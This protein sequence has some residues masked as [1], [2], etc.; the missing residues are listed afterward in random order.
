M[1]KKYVIAPN[2]VS[3]AVITPVGVVMFEDGVATDFSDEQAEFF[4]EQEAYELSDSL[5][6]IEKQTIVE[7]PPAG[8]EP[9]QRDSQQLP[10]LQNRLKA[11]LAF[12]KANNVDLMGINKRAKKPVLEAIYA[13][14][15]E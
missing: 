12:A 13:Q 7:N 9:E 11:I 5:E 8:D 1:N 4:E 14:L 2:N 10:V 3:Q 6:A 15:G